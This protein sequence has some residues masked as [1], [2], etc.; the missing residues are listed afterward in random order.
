MLYFSSKDVFSNNQV[1]A[2][3]HFYDKNP[4]KIGGKERLMITDGRESCMFI[5]GFLAYL[6]VRFP[7]D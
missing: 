7:T 6:S 1:R 2:A 4:C 3:G 5:S